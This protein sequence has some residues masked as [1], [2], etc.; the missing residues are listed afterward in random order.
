MAILKRDLL[1]DVLEDY[2]KEISDGD[3]QKRLAYRCTTVDFISNMVKLTGDLNTLEEDV[4]IN[5]TDSVGNI[6]ST[7]Y[8]DVLTPVEDTSEIYLAQ[9][10][11][12]IIK[13]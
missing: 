4:A 13:E 9:D 7:T 2:T 8:E 10:K 5:T 11:V 12:K 3:P 1:T 6:L